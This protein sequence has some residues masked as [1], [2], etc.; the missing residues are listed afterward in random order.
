MWS[1]SSRTLAPEEQRDCGKKNAERQEHP[2]V[3]GVFSPQQFRFLDHVTEN[4]GRRV[5]T[6]R[7]IFLI[8]ILFEGSFISS[9]FTGCLQ[10]AF[11]G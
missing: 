5:L 2:P 8:L 3:Y 9:S 10:A 1:I 6:D 11:R 7:E 4:K